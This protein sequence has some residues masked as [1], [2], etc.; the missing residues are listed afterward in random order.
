MGGAALIK[1]RRHALPAECRARELHGGGCMSGTSTLNVVIVGA[2]L[3]AW[4]AQPT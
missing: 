3:A 2:G 1:A 4:L